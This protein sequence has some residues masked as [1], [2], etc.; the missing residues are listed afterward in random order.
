MEK[1]EQELEI[2]ES[3]YSNDGVIV[4]K[5]Q[6]SKGHGSDH[7]ECILKIQ[8]NTGLVAEKIAVIVEAKLTF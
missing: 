1:I 5:A 7:V 2:V 4:T 3:I 6:E 8:P